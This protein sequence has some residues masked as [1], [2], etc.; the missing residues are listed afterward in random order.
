[1]QASDVAP[2]RDEEMPM[3]EVHFVVRW[4]DE[5]EVRCYSPSSVVREYLEAGRTYSIDE[6]LRRSREMLAIA[7]ERVRA[8]YG[9]GCTAA[10][11]QLGEIEARAK[12]FDTS[13]SVTVVRFE[14]PEGE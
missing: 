3:P 1:M 8:K 14:P 9:F 5:G 10:T 11:D 12:R 7:S 13:A 6:F 4:P 2:P